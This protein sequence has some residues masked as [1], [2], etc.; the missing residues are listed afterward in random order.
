[1]ERLSYAEF[2]RRMR[3]FN[4]THDRFNNSI[5]GVIVITEGSFSK[6]YSL[7]SRSYEVSSN[8]K[9]W[10]DGM[11][12]YSIFASSLDG[13]DPCIRLEAYLAEERGGKDGWKV[14]YCYFLYG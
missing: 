7:E 1:M 9:A 2:C 10:I 3:E 11:G 8:N 5:R 6:Q 13:S 14:D 4:R 12:G